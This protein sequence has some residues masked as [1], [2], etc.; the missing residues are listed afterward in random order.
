MGQKTKI[1][2]CDS[3][4]NPVT[5]CRHDC[6]Y[7][8]ARGIA[9]RFGGKHTESGE[10]HVLDQP[11]HRTEEM[12]DG[13]Q[14]VGPINPYPFG[15]EPTLH[16]YALKKPQGWKKP[17]SI[18]VCSMADLFGE[19]VPDGWIEA[20]LQA[21]R[22]APQHRYIFLTKAPARLVRYSI[23]HPDNFRDSDNWLFGTT[24]N[25]PAGLI[26][27]GLD[28]LDMRSSIVRLTRFLSI[29]PIWEAFAGKELRDLSHFDWIIVGAETGNRKGR[30]KPEK[31]W[32]NT[33]AEECAE[34]G[35]P[36]FMKESLREIM[37][38]DFR[39]EY[40]W[41]TEQAKNCGICK[42]LSGDYTMVCCNG[43]S[44]RCADFVSA[45]DSCEHWEKQE[46]PR[47]KID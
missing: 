37:G 6:T 8:Y 11:M 43:D 25:T 31:E 30:V 22:S 40:P 28:L 39:Q 13:L 10:L 26:R 15:F 35:V 16:R 46:G 38:A 9:R 17:R 32:V 41:P 18:F 33:I 7:C 1:D 3:S 47:K 4:W 24:V 21:C 34:N 12:G 20:V 36:I 19:W 2:W 23:Q 5:G 27:K 45:T 44:P 14:R 29:E 42:W